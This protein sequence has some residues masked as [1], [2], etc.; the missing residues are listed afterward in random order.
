VSNFVRTSEGDTPDQS[1]RGTD[2]D[3]K[4]SEQAQRVIDITAERDPNRFYEALTLTRAGDTILY[5]RGEF[6]GGMHKK[7]AMA[8]QE[9][10]LVALVQRRIGPEKFEY[11]AQRTKKRWKK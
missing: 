2:T 11:M 4:V 7:N 6:A 10:G 9:A 3:T 8:A 5:H 1:P